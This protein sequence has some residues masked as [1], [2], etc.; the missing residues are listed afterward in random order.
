MIDPTTKLTILHDDNSVFTDHSDNA[1]DYIRDDFSVDLSSTEDY[2]YIGFT[3]PV[4]SAYIEIT[5]ANTNPNELAAEVFD[6]ETS[7]WESIELTD[8]TKG[9]TRSGFM[10]WDSSNMNPTDVD[11][12][13]RN[14][15]R[16]R[17]DNDH[18]ATAIRGIN[19]VFADDNALKSEFFEINNS[20]IL[21]TGETSHINVHVAAR[22][23]IIQMLRNDDYVKS[24]GINPAIIKADQW[25]LFDVFEIREAAIHLALSKIFFNLSD[26]VEDHW[27]T[28][29]RDHQRQFER[30]LPKARLSF[31]SDNDGIEDAN[32]VQADILVQTWNR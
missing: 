3:K 20:S 22:N 17:P 6:T 21:P 18:T 10:F 28:K 25:D 23:R 4:N 30:S 29:Y 12:E 14:W 5:T 7:M 32:E 15:I 8:E 26:D 13:T 2:L 27:W 1:A 19:L 16:L 11:G 9:F 24:N 31:D